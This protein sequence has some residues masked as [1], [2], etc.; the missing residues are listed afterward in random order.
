MTCEASRLLYIYMSPIVPLN[1]TE[2]G[3]ILQVVVWPKDVGGDRAC[4]VVS[5]L[6]FVRA[7]RKLGVEK[8]IERSSPIHDV[9]H[10][11]CIGI[12]KVAFVWRA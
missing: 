6:S 8:P 9:N 11:F 7:G 10:S 4:K 2:T 12:S 5:M 1:A 3:H